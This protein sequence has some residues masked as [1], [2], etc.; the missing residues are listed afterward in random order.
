MN[1]RRESRFQ[2]DR[3]VAIT[4]FG[5]PD[6]RITGRIRNI[7]G[8][9]I[10]LELERPVAAG[11]ALKVELED[12]LLLGEVIYCRQDE[13]SYYAGVELEHSLC[14]LG[15]LSRMVDAFNR[16]M[17]PLEPGGPSGAERTHTVVDGSYERH[18]EAH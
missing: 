13:V 14:G 4:L 2:T 7:S 18:K 8:K 16:A 5:E 6:T 9:G 10:G 12:G 17:A 11:T 1:Q 15:E 3:P